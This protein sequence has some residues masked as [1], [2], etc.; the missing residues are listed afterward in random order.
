ML[1]FF[2]SARFIKVNIELC[3]TAESEKFL[4]DK[5]QCTEEAV[6]HQ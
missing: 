2:L 5:T 3:N 4:E 1:Y 6:S